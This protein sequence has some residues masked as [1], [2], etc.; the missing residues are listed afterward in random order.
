MQLE[1]AGVSSSPT[2]AKKA[3]AELL[4]P[5]PLVTD[6]VLPNLIAAAE[7]I[8]SLGIEAAPEEVCGI[9][10]N[11][12]EGVRVVQL[13]NRAEDPT[14]EYRI[15]PETLR[16]LSLKPDRWR[17][18]AIWHTHPGGHVGPSTRDLETKIP[19]VRYMVVTVPSGEVRWF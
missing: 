10:V 17:H 4:D 9:L 5:S 19:S 18:V 15:D 1:Q 12:T 6:L 7:K 3:K 16:G 13:R 2:L 14:R 11:E 8:L